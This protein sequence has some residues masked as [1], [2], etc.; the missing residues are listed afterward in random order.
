ML[1]CPTACA[2]PP[3]I[4]PTGALTGFVHVYNVPAGTMVPGP[5]T[6]LAGATVKV[7]PLHI[8]AVCAGIAGFGL[9]VTVI[10]KLGPIQLPP[11][12]G[13]TV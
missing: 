13:V 10:V 1:L 9:T 4:A 11:A 7:P 12:V 5:G 2:L 3:V 8:D 6:P